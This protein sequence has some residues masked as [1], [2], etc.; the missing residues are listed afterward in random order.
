MFIPTYTSTTIVFINKYSNL[1]LLWVPELLLLVSLHNIHNYISMNTSPISCRA[2]PPKGTAQQYINAWLEA[3]KSLGALG[4]SWQEGALPAKWG[5]GAAPAT[6]SKQNW[7]ARVLWVPVHNCGAQG[8]LHMLWE[9]WLVLS[10]R[11]CLALHELLGLGQSLLPALQEHMCSPTRQGSS[12]S[13]QALSEATH[14]SA[15]GCTCTFS[16]VPQCLADSLDSLPLGNQAQKKGH[17]PH[18]SATAGV[19]RQT[20]VKETWAE[21]HLHILLLP[22]GKGRIGQ[23]ENKS[24]GCG[25]LP[26]N[27]AQCSG[28]S[29]A[30]P[31][32]FLPAC[33]LSGLPAVPAWGCSVPSFTLRCERSYKLQGGKDE[34]GASFPLLDE[35]QLVPSSA[36]L[37]T[38][39][40]APALH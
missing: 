32:P 33:A 19:I 11:G 22:A 40:T 12:S 34:H 38:S 35:T 21:L 1:V 39:Q 14:T 26:T 6:S 2:F 20:S 23:R 16:Q 25:F 29:G 8:K 27:R 37:C 31:P 36:A 13:C 15:S 28:C 17:S 10:D 7:C 30:K 3:A 5:A 4:A 18:I 24:Q 9:I